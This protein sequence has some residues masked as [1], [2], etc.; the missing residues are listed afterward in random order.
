MITIDLLP[1]NGSHWGN[2]TASSQCSYMACVTA[3][4]TTRV[5]PGKYPCISRADSTEHRTF[6]NSSD[7]VNAGRPIADHSG[8]ET[9]S[10]QKLQIL[11]SIAAYP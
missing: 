7:L 9:S 5:D 3:P 11:L 10:S 4:S 1:G 6:D 8:D 2:T